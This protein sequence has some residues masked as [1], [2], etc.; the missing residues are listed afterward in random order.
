[1][2]LKTT[3]VS[4]LG[5]RLDAPRLR[6]KDRWNAWRPNVALAMQEDIHFDEF[7][8]VHGRNF[9]KLAAEV[10]ADIRT[11]SPDTDV[12]LDELAIANPWVQHSKRPYH[13]QQRQHEMY[14]LHELLKYLVLQPYLQ[15][16][17]V[18]F[19]VLLKQLFHLFHLFQ[20]LLLL[21]L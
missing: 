21:Q 1:M 14:A 2:S 11:A 5:T 17:L 12:R 15:Y 19:Q 10:A 8:L 3:V 13:E 9:R 18:L 6:G 16:L 7:H 4:L 20:V